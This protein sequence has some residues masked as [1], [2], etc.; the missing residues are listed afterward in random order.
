MNND[1]TPD[2]ENTAEGIRVL[3]NLIEDAIAAAG[4]EESEHEEDSESDDD[5]I[6][7]TYD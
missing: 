5:W 2:P 1:F 3:F 6:M 4:G 7:R